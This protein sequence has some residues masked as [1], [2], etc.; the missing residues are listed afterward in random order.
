SLPQVLPRRRRL[1]AESGG[2]AD[3]PGHAAEHDLP[4][5]QD[6]E[7]NAAE[8]GLL[9]SVDEELRLVG[10]LVVP[11]R[12]ERFAGLVIEHDLLA[13]LEHVDAIGPQRDFDA[14][15]FRAAWR[16]VLLAEHATFDLDH[17]E[18]LAR[19]LHREPRLHERSEAPTLERDHR[20]AE[21]MRRLHR[22][23][24]HAVIDRFRDQRLEIGSAD[25]EQLFLAPEPAPQPLHRLVDHVA[26]IERGRAE[27]R[28]F[29][30]PR[31]QSMRRVAAE[32]TDRLM[33]EQARAA[34]KARGAGRERIA[35]IVD[36]L[37]TRG[38]EQRL[39]ARWPWRGESLI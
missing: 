25:R 21:A 18:R 33:P 7:R 32:R 8:R 39:P 23:V 26:A 16:R 1:V 34:A 36:A 29:E 5:A 24:L 12:C 22:D 17:A 28:L 19:A 30:A 35:R 31:A 4:R 20:V 15:D 14:G 10:T 2:A 3:R 38:C 37:G 27:A 11:R 6:R 9:Q 13:G